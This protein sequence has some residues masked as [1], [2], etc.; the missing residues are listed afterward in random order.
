MIKE[1]CCGNYKCE[2]GESES[3]CAKDCYVAS[4]GSEYDDMPL[5]ELLSVVAEKAQVSGSEAASVCQSLSIEM[6][7]GHCF[8]KIALT[9]NQSSYCSSISDETRKDSCYVNYALQTKDFS[10][11][12]QVTHEY[13]RENCI[14][15]REMSSE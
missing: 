9:L 13:L 14:T 8:E 3:S 1:P 4:G 6:Y 12:E 5:D 7:K 11:C 2:S 10:I 15:L